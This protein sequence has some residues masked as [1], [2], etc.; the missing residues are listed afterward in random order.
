M[1]LDSER[2]WVSKFIRKEVEE[3]IPNIDQYIESISS[4]RRQN[5]A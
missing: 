1:T 5:L 3:K 2:R 4:R